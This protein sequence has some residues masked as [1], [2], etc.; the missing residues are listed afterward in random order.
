M[1]RQTY[2]DYEVRTEGPTYTTTVTRQKRNST[3]GITTYVEEIE[4]PTYNSDRVREVREEGP[5]YTT[6]STRQKRNSTGGVTTYIDEVEQPTYDVTATHRVPDT[7]RRRDDSRR[8]N[9]SRN[10]SSNSYGRR[11]G[12]TYTTTDFKN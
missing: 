4:Q 6:T 3:G 9:D 7:N 1:P 5:T 10:R 2:A 12:P 11:D 8:R